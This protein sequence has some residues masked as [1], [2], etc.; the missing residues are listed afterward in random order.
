M[1]A[2]RQQLLRMQQQLTGLSASQKM[3]TASLVVIMIMTMFYWSHY[4]GSSEMAV[5][6]DQPMSAD[7]ITQVTTSLASKNINYQVTGDRIM[8]P[9]DK[10]FELLAELGYDQLLPHDTK[11]GFDDVIAEMSPLDGDAKTDQF[12]NH[13]KE[14]TLASLIS[15]W[16][17]VKSAD[18][19][20]DGTRKLSP[21]HPIDE[22]ASIDITLKSGDANPKLA[23]AACNL[24]CGAQ[25]GLDRPNV[26]VTING[27]PMKMADPDDPF[28]GED[29]AIL[30]AK[31]KF[32]NRYVD[33]I[34]SAIG[35]D[36]VH[37]TVSVDLK[38]QSSVLTQHTVDPK[39]KVEALESQTT[40]SSENAP[41]APQGEPGVAANVGVIDTTAT[42]APA[43]ETS[44]LD[45]TEVK[46]KTDLSYKTEQTNI[47]A[48]DG[49]VVTAS[50]R[51][52]DSY[53]R[54]IWK[55]RNSASTNEPTLA[56]IDAIAKPELAD[57]TRTVESATGLKDESAIAVS[58]YTDLD[59][60]S[61]SGDT[62]SAG[63]ASLP[64]SVG[65]GA[66]DIA[67]GALAVISLFMVSMMVRKSAPQ[68]LLQP[69][70]VGGGIGVGESNGQ[71][72]SQIMIASNVAGEVREAGSM[73]VAQELS[74]EAIEA[75]QVIEQ[76]GTM[77]KENPEAAANL[78]KR[79]LNRE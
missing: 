27:R 67:V 77:V 28:G 56:D 57:I 55:S 66:K 78:V 14:R 74:E 10:K 37:A 29:N 40:T 17:G 24:V 44:T 11:S 58:M 26:R 4:A 60:P 7:E 47:P 64:V 76:V 48:G 5:L 15:R 41:A 43:G 36:G 75:N 65:F 35:I 1:D 39:G 71:T 79:W 3:L 50:V 68:P 9:T 62:A 52:P 69:A 49:A 53:F 23:E 12:F 25:A 54:R 45:K 31:T 32:E 38:T 30:E 33:K 19:I 51:V 6:L 18:V 16:P 21:V 8:V 2:I 20:I 13:A 63:L 59:L 34:I 70:G 73:L 46:N 72:L 61:A 22:T 42:P